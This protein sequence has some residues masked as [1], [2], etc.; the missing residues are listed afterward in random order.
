MR[1]LDL[2]Q[3]GAV[4]IERAALSLLSELEAAIAEYPPDQAGVRIFGDAVLARLL[5]A[6]GLIGKTVAQIIGRSA[7]PVR[8]ILFDKSPVNNWA[9][10]WHQDRT[11]AVKARHD[12]D[13]FGPWSVKARVHHVEPPFYYMERLHTV[14]IHLDD[15][16]ESNAPL[17]VAVGSHKLGRVS[18]SAVEVATSKCEIVECHAKAGDFWLYS[19]AILHASMS[20]SSEAR[21]RVLQVDYADFDLPQPLQ[22]RGLCG[23]RPD[24]DI[25]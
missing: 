21:R 3:D 22:W 10:G 16:D 6:D 4:R 20:S 12:V 14:R 17:L 23:D 15:V 11:I 5:A 8:A 18:E 1:R 24:V 9:L 25:T 13:G 2:E 19:T 7:Q